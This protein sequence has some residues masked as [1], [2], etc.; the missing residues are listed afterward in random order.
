MFRRANHIRWGVILSYLMLFLNIALS[1]L[2]TPLMLRMLGQAEHGL[3]STV[4]SATSWLTLLS[5]G[6]GAGY[7]KFYSQYETAG[8]EQKIA[9]LNGLFLLM[10]TVIGVVA[11]VCGFLLSDNL[12]LIFSDGLTAAE[13]ARARLIT[14]IATVNIAASF[15]A[16]LFNS[17]I[18]AKEKFIQVKLVNLFQCVTVPLAT[19]PVLLSGFGSVGMITVIT[20]VDMIAYAFN[21]AYCFT[22][23]KA[24]FAFSGNQKK[25]FIGIAS[26]S[27]IIA[28]NSIIQQV[29]TSLGKILLARFVNTVSVSVYTIGF[30]LYTYYSSFSSAISSMFVPRVNRIV[31][32]NVED[33]TTLRREQTTLFIRLGRLQ[34]FIQMLMLTGIIFFGAPF[35]RLWAGEGYEN[36]YWVTVL[37]CAAFTIPLCQN[38]GVEIQRAQNKHRLRTVVY[39][40]MT[41]LN[42]LLTV[43]LCRRYGEIG[44]AIGTALAVTVVDTVFMNIYYHKALHIDI[45]AFWKNIGRAAVGL[46][47]PIAV[48]ILLWQAADLSRLW[49]LMGGIALYTAIYIASLWLLSLNAEEKA[50]ITDRFKRRR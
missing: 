46:L 39:A 25:L 36:A 23:L 49:M 43:V 2:Y 22:A 42:V 21:V 31:N 32:Q 19:I 1:I 10:Y 13:E 48:G 15:P 27:L 8:E 41:L 50:M 29:N 28:V 40:V 7:I 18:R 9:Q 45:S 37:L 16:S 47:P 30:S 33:L 38:I 34:F 5:L 6:I 26:F 44:A 35:I 20:V 4:A 3:Y 14:R 11:L 17:I 12:H 24:R